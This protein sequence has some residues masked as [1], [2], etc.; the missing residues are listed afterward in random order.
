MFRAED[1]FN[2]S[3]ASFGLMKPILRRKFLA[4]HKLEYDEGINFAEDLALYV[5]SLFNGAKVI[6]INEAYYIYSVPN[7]PSG[8]SPHS[9]SLKDYRKIQRVGDTLSQKY[10]D[11]ID[12]TLKRTIDAFRETMTLLL[13][14][15]E[16]RSYRQSG[17]YAKYLA[18]LAARPKLTG[19]LVSRAATSIGKRMN[20]RGSAVLEAVRRL[21][22]VL[23]PLLE[24]QRQLSCR[25]YARVW[26]RDRTRKT[27][28]A[29]RREEGIVLAP[30]R[31]EG[32]RRLSSRRVD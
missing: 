7:A 12:P 21:R 20:R 32:W 29:R 23:D 22:R 17:Q 24:E 14:S 30:R 6:M 13:Q 1:D 19:R 9:R 4:D 26:G 8:R 5:E 25:R 16:A 15:N 28:R 18:Y 3:K 11:R 31:R 2:I 10:A 27:T